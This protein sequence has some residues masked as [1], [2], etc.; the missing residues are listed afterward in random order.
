MQRLKDRYALVTGASRGIGLAVA[1]RFAR[2]GASVALNHVG[3]DDDV[4]A[5]ALAA[6][7][8]A[9][10]DA[11]F[12]RARHLLIAADVSDPQAVDA[13]MA[14]AIAA[15]GR[16][17]ILVNNAGIQAQMPSDAFDNAALQKIVAVDLLGAAYCAKAAIHHFLERQE[18]GDARGGTVINTS[19]VHQLIP[20]PGFL[21][22]SI[23]KGGMGNLT[24]TLALEF[25]DRKVRVNAVAPGAII[26]DIN[27]SWIHDKAKQAEV[28]AHIPMGYAAMPDDVAPL[29]AFLA[30][31]EASY[32][33]GQTVYVDGGL[34][35]YGDFRRNWSS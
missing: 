10:R 1:E 24:R 4:A 27:D 25:S 14:Q 3:H 15:L 26:T 23:S 19:S 28:E 21:A 6:V 17:D 9:S 20:K 34:T 8:K 31:D 29:F 30:S 13:M 35:L 12:A 11:G 5:A 2:E 33:T 7:E 22:Y 16:L 32:I 18:K